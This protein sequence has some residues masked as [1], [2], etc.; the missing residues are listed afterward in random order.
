MRTKWSRIPNFGYVSRCSLSA[1]CKA[2]WGSCLLICSFC[3]FRILL[4]DVG[5]L[6]VLC[7]DGAPDC[8]LV[9]RMLA[10]LFPA[11]PSENPN[12]FRQFPGSK[13]P[14]K[15]F[16]PT[17]LL[18]EFWIASGGIRVTGMSEMAALTCGPR[19]IITTGALI[20]VRYWSSCC[21]PPAQRRVICSGSVMSALR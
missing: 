3:I 11:P 15:F 9:P 10:D 13:K 17:S 21:W 7:L 4:F 12:Q 19:Y 14:Q 20:D 16:R 18:M 2:R 5:C 1:T 6:P 8:S